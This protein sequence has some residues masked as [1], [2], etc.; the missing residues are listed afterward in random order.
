MGAGLSRVAVSAEARDPLT[1]VGP[2]PSSSVSTLHLQLAPTDVAHVTRVEGPGVTS[3]EQ[4]LTLTQ[5]RNRVPADTPGH[6]PMGTGR[7]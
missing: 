7:P 2:R 5:R 1:S 4:Q 6:G 3:G